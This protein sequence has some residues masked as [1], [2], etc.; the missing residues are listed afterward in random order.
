MTLEYP[1]QNDSTLKRTLKRVRLSY[2]ETSASGFRVTLLSTDFNSDGLDTT[3]EQAGLLK[4]KLSVA[5]LPCGNLSHPVCIE[6]PGLTML[7]KQYTT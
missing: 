4:P 7:M 6:S 2:D 3:P 5:V 1:P